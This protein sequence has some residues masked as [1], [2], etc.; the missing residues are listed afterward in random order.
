ME[1]ISKVGE[2]DCV[3]KYEGMWLQCTY[4]VITNNNIQ[5]YAFTAAVRD[6]TEHGWEKIR[7]IMI[8]EPANCGK[9]FLLAPLHIIFKTF[10]NL[11]IERYAQIGV[12][13][14]ECIFL[15]TLGGVGN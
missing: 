7:Y 2:Q 9:T 1:I 5:P 15:T 11:V 13:T 14:F 4:E 3:Q 10:T 6:L 12:E 8:I